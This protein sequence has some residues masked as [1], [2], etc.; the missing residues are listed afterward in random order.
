MV[1]ADVASPLDAGALCGFDKPLRVDIPSQRGRYAPGAE[2]LAPWLR[3]AGFAKRATARRISFRPAPAKQREGAGEGDGAVDGAE[4]GD[5]RAATRSRQAPALT[6]LWAGAE[7]AGA[8]MSLWEGTFDCI[9][10]D[11]P[12]RDGL[13][14]LL[15]QGH[16]LCALAADGSL[17]GVLQAEFTA[18]TG[19][20]WHLAIQP[21]LRG[22]GI[23]RQLMDAFHAKGQ[24]GGSRVFYAWVSD[25]DAGA[26]D[27]YQKLGYLP[28]GRESDSYIRI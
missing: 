24:A 3:Q 27:F 10:N 26:W 19:W 9:A 18:S 20:L 28:D 11:V 4:A 25:L 2:A 14:T 16:I 8:I 17:A 13:E 1:I 12:T 23:G 21:S 5:T 22:Q 7:W 15:A 6:L